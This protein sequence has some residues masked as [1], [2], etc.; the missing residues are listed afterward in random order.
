MLSHPRPRCAG[1]G[2][3]RSRCRSPELAFRMITAVDAQGQPP[4]MFPE[5]FC[6]SRM[7][8]PIIP[9]YERQVRRKVLLLHGCEQRVKL[10]KTMSVMQQRIIHDETGQFL[11]RLPATISKRVAQ[12]H[13][14]RNKPGEPAQ[15]THTRGYCRINVQDLT[16]TR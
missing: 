11:S 7:T 1:F 9:G 12:E 13:Q 5:K 8:T 10:K 15:G 14:R 2:E 6:D 3:E 4:W 16:S